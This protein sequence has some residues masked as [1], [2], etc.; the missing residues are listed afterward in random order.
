MD[1]QLK[2]IYEAQN[3]NHGTRVLVD[4][5]W[6]RGISKKLQP[7]MIGEKPWLLLMSSANGLLTITGKCQAFKK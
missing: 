7:L 6:P 2:R 1:V 5:L 4:R 3:E